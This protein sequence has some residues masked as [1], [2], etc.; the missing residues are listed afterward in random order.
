[1]SGHDITTPGHDFRDRSAHAVDD[2][3]LQRALRNL[4]RR[5]RTAAAAQAAHPDW[6]DRAAAVRRE[7][8]ADLDGWLDRL[9]NSLAARG[10]HV[11]RAATPADARR[12]VLDIAR[13]SGARTVVKSKSMATEEIDL[14][15][16]L[17]DAGIRSI[18]TD[19]GEYIVQLAGERPSH[20]ITPA[21]HKTLPQIR[22]V[23]AR[24]AGSE[25]PVDR[26]ALTAWTRARLRTEFLRADLGITG[27]NFAAADTGTLVLV[28][29]EGNGRFCTTVPRVHVAVM[30]IEK[31]VPRLADVAF[32]VPLLTS[33]ATG[34]ALSNYV[35]MV[36]GPRRAGEVDGPDELHVVFLD[37]RRRT[38]LGTRYEEML[39]CIRCGA[40][41]NVCP[42][43]RHVS[44]HAYDAVYSGP[45]G[46]VLT[47]LLSGGTEGT[48]LPYGSS[49][50]HACSDAC[51]V[52]IPLADLIV[53]LRADVPAPGTPARRARRR[54]WA[55]W[56]RAWS[57][58]RG[59]RVTTGMAR[60]TR[61]VG[62]APGLGRWTRTRTLPRPAAE[63]FRARY[64]KER[65]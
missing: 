6:K 27:L 12:V 46:K 10:V 31:V 58:P 39:A 4:D 37:N 23:L 20:M 9:E 25:L 21:I 63:P 18:E 53:E 62:W 49:L 38:L 47:P 45:M 2:P 50:C 60:L 11:H 17:E 41:L 43:Y 1:M 22:D 55:A 15:N 7:T 61:G 32:M 14:G 35:T 33:H 54:F 40:C 51:P 56:A 8:L 57:S 52:R 36:S 34:Q 19:L 65:G 29:N 48:D 3:D 64:A 44:G 13:A 24:E 42:V 30:P 5:L 28:T 16:A 26:E 59:Y